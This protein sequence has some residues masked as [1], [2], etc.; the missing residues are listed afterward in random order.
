[1]AV[2]L[3]AGSVA[4]NLS[5]GDAIQGGVE[6]PVTV[7]SCLEPLTMRA[8]PLRERGD[9][10]MTGERGFT[11]KPGNIC[12]LTNNLGSCQLGAPKNCQQRRGYSSH[13]EANS[14]L[15]D[16]DLF[17]DSNDAGQFS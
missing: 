14:P 4:F 15:Q 13:S 9:S 3:M 5:H 12:G 11:A 8:R 6:L 1:M 2:V 7:P 17:G 10:R 16:F